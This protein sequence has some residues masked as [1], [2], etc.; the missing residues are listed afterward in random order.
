MSIPD[1]RFDSMIEDGLFETHWCG[2]VGGK[3]IILYTMGLQKFCT[4]FI[5]VNNGTYY[6]FNY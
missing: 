6:K 3:I 5:H 1:S 4:H 2:W